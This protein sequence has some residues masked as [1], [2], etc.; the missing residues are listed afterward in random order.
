VKAG[1]SVIVAAHGNSLRSMIMQLEK[2][3]PEQILKV[4]LHTGA[5]I[6]YRLKSDG[7]VQ[8]KRALIG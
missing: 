6:I 2:L 7:S 8:D 4:E 3:S 5:P 1:R